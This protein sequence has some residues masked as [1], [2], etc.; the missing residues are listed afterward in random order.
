MA[1]DDLYRIALKYDVHG[2]SNVNV[3]YCKQ[4]AAFTSN[5]AFAC[6]TYM[7]QQLMPF[8]ASIL[9][10]GR[11][12]NFG[13]DVSLVARTTSD[14]GSNSFPISGSGP[15]GAALPPANAVV[16]SIRTGFSGRSRR[17]RIFLGGL[18]GNLTEA[19]TLNTIGQGIYATFITNLQQV[20][21]GGIAAAPYRLGV[22]SREKYKILSNPFDDYFKLANAL[23]IRQ[24][25]ATMRSRKVG[26]GA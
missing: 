26:V 25:I 5:N 6:A 20:L 23:Q 15:P 9:P 18:S 14:L 8:F 3:I 11:G 7:S 17:G 12:A 1:V 10:I 13:A 4:V 16:C 24:P 21:M 19:G 22:F 2:Q